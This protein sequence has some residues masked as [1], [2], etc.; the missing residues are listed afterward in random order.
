MATAQLH[1]LVRRIKEAALGPGERPRTDRE[2]LD[3][4]ASGGD[5]AAFTDLVER[6]GPMVLRTCRR[7]LRHEQDAEDAF[8]ATFLALAQRPG[9]IRRREAVASWLYGVAY[10]TAMK[11]KRSAARR[12]IHEARLRERTPT[13]TPT[14]TWDDVQEVLHEEIQR[15]PASFRA[16]FVLCVLDGKTEA[17]AAAELGA[18]EGTLSWRLARARQ[19]LRQQLTRRGIELSAV[20][21][22]LSVAASAGEAAVPVVLADATA[23]FGPLVATG[24][25]A[26]ALVP[27]HIAALAAGVTRAMFLTKA[28]FVTALLITLG[29]VAA[30][31]SAVTQEAPPPPDKA[32][33]QAE[34]RPPA[35]VQPPAAGEKD[36]VVDVRGRVL[37][38]DGNRVP[39]AKLV[40]IYASAEKAPEKVWATTA[41]DGRF[42]FSVARSIGGEARAGS[43]WDNTYVVA[44]AEGHGLAW[45]RVRPETSGD[46][47]LRL[48]KDDV[49]IQGRIIDLQGKPV[50]GATIRIDGELLVP[51]KGDLT[52]WLR[53][54]AANKPGAADMGEPYFASLYSA[55]LAGLFPDGKTG[56]DGRFQINGIGRER[57]ARLRVEGPTIATQQ[58][59]AM[60][61]KAENVRQAPPGAPFELLALPTRPVVGV[62]HD[63]E[64]GKP[65]A[66]VTVRS[67]RIAR[68]GDFNGLVRTTTDTEG[69]Y[70]L[71]GLP[72][73]AGNEIT[74]ETTGYSPRPEDRP[75]FSAIHPVGDPLGL[76]AVTVDFALQRGVWVEGRLIDKATGKA[77][78]MQA[79]VEYFCFAD[80]P[81]ASALP[82]PEGI[83]S[84]WTRKDGSFRILALP[85][86][87]VIAV[88]AGADEYR[89]GVGAEGIKGKLDG[90]QLFNTLPYHLY[91][92]NFHTL[93]EV[94]PRP[95]DESITCDMVLDPGRT[96]QGTVVDPE[97]KPLAGARVA[98]LRPMGYWEAQPLTMAQFTL[99][100]LSPGERRRLQVMHE[101]RKL[102]GWLEVRGDDKGPVRIRLEPW[103]AVTG[104]LIAPDGVPVTNVV[105]SVG[106]PHEAQPGKDGKFQLDG[107]APG[108]TYSLSVTKEPAYLLEVRGKGLDKLKV[109]GGQT[110]DLGD[111]E[112]RP[113]E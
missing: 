64:T 61:H 69:R 37:G 71:V 50:A 35:N 95:G 73:S 75:Y 23:R 55:S 33:P 66:G 96:L 58:I 25:P 88:R 104:R 63:K 91:P 26:V 102:A 3:D 31:A 101:G 100:G 17:A 32:R 27:S 86:R 49:P 93:V 47:T 92:G 94:S 10:R 14:R 62:V 8:Q 60:T 1:T 5:A 82:L 54:L 19:R 97:G 46:L 78:A 20:L 90:G 29:L 6:H 9:S 108:L 67:S 16:A 112:V 98:G 40:F 36:G 83:P 18:K 70:R 79:G 80:N 4:F 76:E 65:L 56:P 13:A 111:I 48:V 24:Q 12:R 87:G 72:K 106:L 59:K 53:A 99:R 42:H 51:T 105:V 11:A 113:M 30:G 45:A 43:S 77:V 85:G 109:G 68:A 22:A 2:L 44:A 21:A 84:H 38:P 52:E 39:G 7:A 89:M 110:K 28:K 15:L 74:V 107:L 34:A 41:A 103:G 81:L 57:V